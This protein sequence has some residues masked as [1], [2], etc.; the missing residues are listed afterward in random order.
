MIVDEERTQ[1][2]N[3]SGVVSGWNMMKCGEK[4]RGFEGQE[5]RE[6]RVNEEEWDSHIPSHL[7]VGRAWLLHEGQQQHQSHPSNTEPC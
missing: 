6:V 7:Q 1:H 2:K 3:K 4:Q 5:E